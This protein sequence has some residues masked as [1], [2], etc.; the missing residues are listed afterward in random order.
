MNNLHKMLNWKSEICFRRLRKPFNN[1]LA[2]KERNPYR[3]VRPLF[4]TA[5]K[6]RSEARIT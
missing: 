3:I 5:S 6:N 4:T 2:V 1:L